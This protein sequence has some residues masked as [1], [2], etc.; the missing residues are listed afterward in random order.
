MHNCAADSVDSPPPCGEGFGVG[1]AQRGNAEPHRITPLPNPPPQQAAGLP[2]S[3]QFK[4]D[5]TPAGRGWVRGR[6]QTE[7]VVALVVHCVAIATLLI[8]CAWAQPA[9]AQTAAL[10][11]PAITLAVGGK[12]LVAFLPLTIAERL[13]LFEQEGLRVEINDFQ[14]GSR[15][16]QSL[17][18][19]SA[20]AVCGSYE[21]TILM[22]AKGVGIKAIALQNDSLGTVIGL[23]KEKAKS[24]RSPKDLAGL[25]LGVTSPGSAS[26]LGIALLLAK[27]GVTVDKVSII[28][29]GTGA[30]AV[31]AMKSGQIDGMSNF[32]PAILMLERDGVLV[33]IVDSRTRKGLDELY[34]GPIAG[35]SF[36]VGDDFIK[37]NPRTAQAF[38]NAIVK[39][40]RWLDKASV[41]EIVAAVPSEYYSG[42]DRA[43]YAKMVELNRGAFSKD[44]RIDLKAAENT[45]RALAAHEAVLK[46]A[47]VD[48]KETFDNTFVEKAAAA[49]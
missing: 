24:Y 1:V 26:F 3:G 16:L 43:T 20:D 10:E 49:R 41:E 34:G 42:G 46:D 5:P 28:G 36:Y 21:H 15:A 12:T 45:Y 48:L 30:S 33:P 8:A 40:L 14:G 29:V 37:K 11:K 32:D 31:A 18:G 2:A 7:C 4:G 19:G 44:G 35:S 38:A 39:A 22:R 27:E 6:E 47:K 17:V 23:S 9:R 13:R 25:K